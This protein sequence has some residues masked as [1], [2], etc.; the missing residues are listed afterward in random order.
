MAT[1]AYDSSLGTP[2]ILTGDTWD[3][4]N[5]DLGNGL[6]L[7][8]VVQLG[9]AANSPNIVST[10]ATTGLRGF[11]N[12]V[13]TLSTASTLGNETLPGYSAIQVTLGQLTCVADDHR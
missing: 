10:G 6:R 8:D 5:T 12:G 3:P 9:N 11:P 2:P 1:W 7:S 13:L 4:N